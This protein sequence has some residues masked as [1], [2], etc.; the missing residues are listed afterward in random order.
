MVEL[1]FQLE[2]VCDIDWFKEDEW[3]YIYL[4]LFRLC[5]LEEHEVKGSE[6]LVKLKTY[7][8]E[9][10]LLHVYP[11]WEILWVF[12]FILKC[13]YWCSQKSRRH[14][15]ETVKETIFSVR[16]KTNHLLINFMWN[17]KKLNGSCC[18]LEAFLLNSSVNSFKV[19]PFLYPFWGS[20]FVFFVFLRNGL[21]LPPIDPD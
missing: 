4:K 11:S 2:V 15:S 10:I 6:L 9:K 16:F 5:I 18:S 1:H 14:L 21:S 13:L 3:K 12:E 19:Y 17:K 7:N 8:L 20:T